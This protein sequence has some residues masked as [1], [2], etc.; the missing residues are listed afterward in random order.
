MSLF[1]L[2]SVAE[3]EKTRVGGEKSRN[4]YYPS[5]GAEYTGNTDTYKNY[6]SAVR[7]ARKEIEEANRQA[8]LIDTIIGLLS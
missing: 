2:D 6:E 3:R 1:D 8:D 4:D 7:D 5:L